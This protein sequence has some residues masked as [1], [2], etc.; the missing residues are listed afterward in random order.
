[1]TWLSGKAGSYE[2]AEKILMRIGKIELDDSTIWRHVKKRGEVLCE[3]EEKR[4]EK[5]MALPQV[6]E[7]PR[8]PSPGAD[9]MG[10]GIDGAMV[11]I[12]EE[13]WKEFKVGSVYEI[14]ERPNRDPITGEWAMV[15]CAVNNSYVAHLGDAQA[16]GPLI[17]SEAQSRGWE[18]ARETQT[19]GD[20]AT[21][22][23]NLAD[24]YFP[25]SLRTLD[26]YHGSEY[27]HTAARLL[28]PTSA[29]ATTRWFN[30]AE[31][32]LFQGQAEAIADTIS[33]KIDANP[34]LANDELAAAVTYFHN[35]HKRM[36]YMAFREDGFPIG[37][38]M[39]ESAAKQFKARFTGP[40]MRWSRLG[41]Q[42][43][44]PIRAAVLSD[45]FDTLWDSVFT[46]PPN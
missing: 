3:A 8:Q 17:W 24:L 19:I 23:W 40:G 44:I 15:A 37:S 10:V 11:N 29:S 14:A 35:N 34:A 5:A 45:S 18:D 12:R 6:G 4:K 25:L 32:S 16:F 30:Q 28:C 42:R 20:G 2:E 1:V 7:R 13:G 9:R 41:L 27:L 38:G 36:Q 43:L 21:W 31:T 39:V 46:S 33:D 22:I 26:W